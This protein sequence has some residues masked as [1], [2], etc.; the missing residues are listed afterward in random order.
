MN[1]VRKIAAMLAIVMCFATSN[2]AFAAGPIYSENVTFDMSEEELLARIAMYEGGNYEEQVEIMKVVASWRYIDGYPEDIKSII[3]QKNY[4]LI[5]PEVWNELASPSD[6]LIEVAA[7]ILESGEM[8]HYRQY[9]YTPD[10]E[11]YSFM[12]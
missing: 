9:I 2:V 4:F 8:R 12:H 5:I 3:C 1:K 7:E 10:I 6:E 11:R